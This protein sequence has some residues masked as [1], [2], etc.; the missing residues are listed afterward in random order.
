MLFLKMFLAPITTTRMT[1]TRMTRTAPNP[2]ICGPFGEAS[3]QDKC[4]KPKLLLL[5]LERVFWDNVFKK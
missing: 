2:G 1:T 5:M 3:T 4:G